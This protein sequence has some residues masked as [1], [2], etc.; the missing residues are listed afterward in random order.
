MARTY[1]KVDWSKKFQYTTFQK[2]YTM[3][4]VIDHDNW[5]WNY[6]AHPIMG[7][8]NYLSWRNKGGRVWDSFLISAIN[9]AEHEYLIAASMQRPSINDLITT[10]ILGS[11]LGET[12]YQ[13][14]HHFKKD[15]HPSFIKKS[16]IF[17]LD[18][19][20]DLRCRLR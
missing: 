12:C 16:F 5:D 14:R 8:I 20:E 11:I 2:A 18:P 4:P 6:V 13:L 9:S 7:S 19:V 15:A 17:M 10:P 1:K 3:P